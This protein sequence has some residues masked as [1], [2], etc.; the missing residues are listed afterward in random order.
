MTFSNVVVDMTINYN[1]CMNT[2]RNMGNLDYK[3]KWRVTLILKTTRR[4]IRGTL[5]TGAL[6]FEICDQRKGKNFKNIKKP[7]MM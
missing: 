4:Q 6:L 3:F 5:T 2:F 1:L 7:R